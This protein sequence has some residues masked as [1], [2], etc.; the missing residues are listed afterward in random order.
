MSTAN[1][2]PVAP[3]RNSQQNIIKNSEFIIELSTIFTQIFQTKVTTSNLPAYTLY[4]LLYLNIIQG[5]I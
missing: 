5:W 1:V 2:I 3:E 4:S